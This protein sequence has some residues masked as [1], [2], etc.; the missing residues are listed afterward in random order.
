MDTKKATKKFSAEVRE[1][2]VRMVR[3]HQGEHA[4]QWAA[5]ASIA[6]K[7]GCTAQT[8]RNWVRQAERDAGERPGADDGRS[9]ADQGAGAGEPRASAGQRDFAQGVGLFCPGG[10]R[11]PVQAMI[12]F[13]DDHREAHGVEPICKVLPIAP[14]SYR[15]HAAQAARSGEGL[16]PRARRDAVLREKIQ[17]VF[18]E[19]FAVYGARKVWRQLTREGESVAR[20]T[21]E[22]L[23]RAMG[24]QGVV[25]G[26]PVKTTV[27]DKAAPCPQDKVNRQFQAPRPNALWV[28]DFTYVATWAGFVYVAFV[29][30]AFARR[31][32]GWRARARR[33]RASCSTRSNRRCST[34][35]RSGRRPR[36][37]QRP[38]RAICLD[39]IHGTPEGRRRRAVRRQRRRQL[40]QRARRDDQRTLQGRGHLAARAVAQLRAGRVRHARMG[41]LVQQQETAGA[42]RK[43]SAGRSRSALLCAN[44]RARHGG[45]TQ[46]KWPP[47][48]P[49]RF[50]SCFGRR[51]GK[52][53][54]VTGGASISWSEYSG[55][56]VALVNG[57]P[58]ASVA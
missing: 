19:N 17:R 25:R 38:R 53:A 9:R 34:P 40:R 49:G 27:S 7:I 37:S 30:D 24:L 55:V 33:M 44:R 42:D 36:P 15:A 16:S 12:A 39:Q 41:G 20:C 52:D 50:T 13:I 57:R 29:I 28:S 10:A 58:N 2:A 56:E 45:V 8:L 35:A 23:M 26:K 4:S 47:A 5:I 11:P 18:D 14:S 31:I 46:T 21:V 32:V 51:I 54:R 3:E 48:N 6:A 43:H 22:R 1:R